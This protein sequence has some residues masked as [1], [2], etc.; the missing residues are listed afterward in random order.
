MLDGN[1]KD[2]TGIRVGVYGSL[3]KHLGNHY[4]LDGAEYLGEAKVKDSMRMV[5]LGHF[6]A[7]VKCTPDVA[8]NITLEVYKIDD[9]TLGRL[10]GLEGHPDWYRREK[11]MTRFKNVWVYMMDA[12]SGYD[13]HN[14]VDSGDWLDYYTAA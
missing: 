1:K 5:S 13:T 6:P 4:L 3:R 7:V 9:A 12:N 11:V 10:D 14:P 8:T 2:S